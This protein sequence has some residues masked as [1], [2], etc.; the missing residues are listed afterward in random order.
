MVRRVQGIKHAFVASGVRHDLLVLPPQRRLFRELVEHHVGGQM[1][2]APEH[3]ARRPLRLMG[4]PPFRVYQEFCDLFDT[5]KRECGKQVFLVPYLIAGH[6]GS[7]L[8]DAVDLARFV[9]RLGH[10][11]EQVQQFTPTPMTASS[12]M[13]WS[14]R[15][16]DSGET[17]FAPSGAEAKIQKA[18]A[19]FQNPRNREKLQQ[20]F[21]KLGKAGILTDL[22]GRMPPHRKGKSAPRGFAGRPGRAII[23]KRPRRAP[24]GGG[25][26]GEEGA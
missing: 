7:T 3:V 23:N 15:D 20:Y 21:G 11:V 2:A 17:V 4:K 18:L 26:S 24:G 6:P 19:Q 1:K 8:E 10:F 9:K 25:K 12:C 22:Y 5:L 14:R 16:P 13:Y